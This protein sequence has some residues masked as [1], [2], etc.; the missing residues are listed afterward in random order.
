M[1]VRL[2]QVLGVP[3]P[4]SKH[5]RLLNKGLVEKMSPSSTKHTLEHQKT[6]GTGSTIVPAP[7]R[8][9]IF[10]CKVL[11]GDMIQLITQGDNAPYI[12]PAT[13]IMVEN[14]AFTSEILG[15]HTQCCR[16]HEDNPVAWKSELSDGCNLYW[17]VHFRGVGET[18]VHLNTASNQRKWAESF[19]DFHNSLFIPSI[20]RFPEDIHFAGD[21]TPQNEANCPPLSDYLTINDTMKCMR[22]VYAGCP[23]GQILSDQSVMNKYY[24]PDLHEEVQQV[25]ASY[26]REWELISKG[27]DDVLIGERLDTNPFQVPASDQVST[28]E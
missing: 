19:I 4:T 2:L 12:K 1:K 24:A 15:I 20:Y 25:F 10:V 27:G 21:L 26:I 13:D 28:T 3:L 22:M 6:A 16:R 7:D 23:I 5:L 18:E 14:P 8:K 17:P 11:S 9:Q